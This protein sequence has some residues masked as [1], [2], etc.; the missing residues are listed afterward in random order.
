MPKAHA[1]KFVLYAILSL[2]IFLLAGLAISHRP[3]STTQNTLRDKGWGFLYLGVLFGFE[4]SGARLPLIH[5]RTPIPML[6]H[7]AFL[8]W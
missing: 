3:S 1:I 2:L 6:G 8:L 7:L 4:G 5:R